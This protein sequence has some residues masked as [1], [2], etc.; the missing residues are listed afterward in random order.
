VLAPPVTTPPVALPPVDTELPPVLTPPVM[1]APP[2]DE[3]IPPLPLGSA[4]S[5]PQPGANANDAMENK[6]GTPRRNVVV[7]MGRSVAPNCSKI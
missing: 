6:I 7:L 3:T 1:E 4:E 5:L 2:E